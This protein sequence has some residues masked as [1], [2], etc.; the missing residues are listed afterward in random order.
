MNTTPYDTRIEGDEFEE[1]CRSVNDFVRAMNTAH[2]PVTVNPIDTLEGTTG[3]FDADF[4]RMGEF[5]QQKRAELEIAEEM[6]A[7]LRYAL[8]DGVRE[9]YDQHITDK[10]NEREN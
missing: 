6:Y 9:R 4:H 8:N 3:D 7:T 5:L 10:F 2:G 1:F